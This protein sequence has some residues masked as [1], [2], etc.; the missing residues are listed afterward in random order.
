M[1][2]ARQGSPRPARLGR[3]RFLRGLVISGGAILLGGCQPSAS[4]PAPPSAPAAASASGAATPD[5]NGSWETTWSSWIAAARNEGKV[6]VKGPPAPEVRTELPRAFQARYG[7]EVEYLGSPTGPFATQVQ[8]ER[9]AGIYSTDV[10]LAGADSMYT[11]FYQER[12]LAPL[13]PVL[14]LPEATDPAAWPDGKL[15]FMDPEQQYILRLNNSVQIMGQINTAYVKPE[16]LQSY[17]DLLKPEYKGKIAA[18]DPAVSGSGVG[19][20]AYLYVTLGEDFVRRLYVDQQPVLSRDDR[21]LADWVARGTY[22]IAIG[23]EFASDTERAALR[24]GGVNI[25]N[26][27]RPADAPGGVSPSFGLLGLFTNAPHPYAAQVFVN[28]I[29]AREGMTVWSK[30][31]HAVPVRLDIDKSAWSPDLVPDPNVKTYHDSYGWDFVLNERQAV[32]QKLRAL[33][34]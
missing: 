4:A 9:E 1:R 26:L 23:G 10:V 5:D 18:F 15:W 31:L 24:S 6:V 11:V 19:T 32:M 30:G 2:D 17:Y 21:Q 27:P 7:V 3:R 20:A 34:K 22:P 29:A 8:H 28:W 14:I 25:V 33:I 13:P 12:M 16:D